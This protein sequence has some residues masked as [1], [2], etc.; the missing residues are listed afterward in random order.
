M[1]D[2]PPKQKLRYI[3]A[4][5]SSS[6]SN[7]EMVTL[8]KDSGRAVVIPMSD[9]YKSNASDTTNNYVDN[10]SRRKDPTKD[11]RHCVRD[12]CFRYVMKKGASYCK[13]HGTSI[14][15]TCNGQTK[16]M[17]YNNFEEVLLPEGLAH[18]SSN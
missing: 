1:S 3:A 8:L 11:E 2:A 13:L 4:I 5:G 15:S 10:T 14:N 12:G 7:A 16:Q 17:A 18:L 9:K 6:T